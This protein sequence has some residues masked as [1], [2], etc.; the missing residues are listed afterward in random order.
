MVGGG[1]GVHK[2]MSDISWMMNG[3][4]A[5]KSGVLLTQISEHLV[6]SDHGKWVINW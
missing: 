6:Q 1:E 4:T 2:K 5:T 3:T